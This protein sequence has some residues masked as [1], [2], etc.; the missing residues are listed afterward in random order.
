MGE[1]HESDSIWWCLSLCGILRTNFFS[2]SNLMRLRTLV[3]VLAAVLMVSLAGCSTKDEPVVFP[4]EPLCE[5]FSADQ[6]APLLPSGDYH[7][8]DNYNI[9]IIYDTEYIYLDGG[10]AISNGA[11]GYLGVYLDLATSF[12][13]DRRTGPLPEPA[14]ESI[15]ISLTAPSVGRVITSGGCVE[16]ESKYTFYTAWV[17]Y[18]GGRYIE[19]WPA[20][21]KINVSI[22]P[23][24]GRDGV[25][26]AAQVIQILLDFIDL[27]YRADPSAAST[28]TS[29]P[30]ATPVPSSAH[31]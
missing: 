15:P 11:I 8:S 30:G 4:E 3:L 7:F 27:S 22:I 18:W 14:C 12:T 23:R 16:K 31:S 2:D 13:E 5:F 26:D 19:D 20:V 1:H 29:P 24:K 21:T 28:E 6:I 17:L 25:Q 9:R 10:C